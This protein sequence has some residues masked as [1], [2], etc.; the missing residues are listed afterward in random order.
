MKT[1]DSEVQ[2]IQSLIC[3]FLPKWYPEIEIRP[4][5]V[6]FSA[7]K[8]YRWSRHLIYEVCN[9]I[10]VLLKTILVKLPRLHDESGRIQSNARPPYNVVEQEYHSLRLLYQ[11]FGN[12]ET[13]DL[14]AVRPLS[15]CTET[16]ALF[17]EYKAGVTFHSAVFRSVGPFPKAADL[18]TYTPI[19]YISNIY[20]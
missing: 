6:R 16:N 8:D 19:N 11:H 7:A 1:I 15:F 2:E 14:T 3:N 13:S 17:L 9:P 5:T 10:G 20:T 12:D 4:T 18:I